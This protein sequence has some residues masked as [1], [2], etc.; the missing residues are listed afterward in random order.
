MCI[1]TEYVDEYAVKLGVVRFSADVIFFGDESV[2]FSACVS[3][4]DALFP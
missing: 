4:S 1:P 3:V 2:E